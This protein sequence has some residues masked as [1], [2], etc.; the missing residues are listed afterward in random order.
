VL[1]ASSHACTPRALVRVRPGEGLSETDITQI[2]AATFGEMPDEED[3]E[4]PLLAGRSGPARSRESE[5]G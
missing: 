1:L 3:E 5:G 4:E 2:V